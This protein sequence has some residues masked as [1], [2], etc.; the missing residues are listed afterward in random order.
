[1]IH[2]ISALAACLA[3][4]LILSACKKEDSPPVPQTGQQAPEGQMPPN[5]PG[6]MPP[7]QMPPDTMMPPGQMPPGSMSQMP[8]GQMPPGAGQGMMQS[9]PRVP[10]QVIVPDSVKGRWNG[11]KLVIEDKTAK[12][13]Q[14]YSVKLNSDFKVPGS[15]LRIHVGEFLPDF[16]MDGR[17]LTS[18]SNDPRNPALGIQVFEGEKQIFPGPGKQ[19]G[20][21][22]AKVPTIHP[23]EHPKYSVTLKEGLKKG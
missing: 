16:R 3:L 17:N 23:F 8:P 7:G 10:A 22:F 21:L 19:W 15:S 12:T 11:V 6:M 5:A 9:Q 18:G 20:W 2:K 4:V 14:E 13:K 1:M